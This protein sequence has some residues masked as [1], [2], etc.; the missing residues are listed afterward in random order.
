MLNLESG[1]HAPWGQ[2]PWGSHLCMIHATEG[3]Y[4]EVSF[5]EWKSS[6]YLA[7]ANMVLCEPTSNKLLCF[8]RKG[9]RGA[10]VFMNV[11]FVVVSLL[12]MQKFMTWNNLQFC[13]EINLNPRDWWTGLSLLE[14]NVARSQCA[15]QDMSVWSWGGAQLTIVCVYGNFFSSARK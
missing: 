11:T 2:G 4:L 13:W 7:C 5:N 1:P 10:F 9:K 8:Q 12:A 6:S 3:H 15:V 14:A